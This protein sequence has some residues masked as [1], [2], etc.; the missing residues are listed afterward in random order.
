MAENPFLHEKNDKDCMEK[1]CPDREPES[2]IS[3]SKMALHSVKYFWVTQ[4][5]AKRHC[6]TNNNLVCSFTVLRNGIHV[7]S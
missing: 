3:V 5:K 4:G 7:V 6:K 1:N 2:C